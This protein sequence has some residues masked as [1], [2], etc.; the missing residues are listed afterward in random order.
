MQNQYVGD[1]GDFGKYGM[2]RALFPEAK[3]GVV[4]Y[5]VPNETHNNDGKH[6]VYLDKADYR[7][8]DAV[9]AGKLKI[10]IRDGCRSV[11][12]IEQ[13]G[14][15]NSHTVFY[16][17]QLTYDGITA[18]GKSDREKRLQN[19]QEWLNAAFEA[20]RNCEV[21]FLDPDNGLQI[22]SCAK[23][24]QVKSGM[25][26]FWDKS[27]GAIKFILGLCLL[28]FVYSSTAAFLNEFQTAD[29]IWRKYFQYKAL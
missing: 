3:L 6:V 24:N 10:L 26:K 17:R 12:K 14:L 22:P 20:T 11:E 15:F 19:R 25:A 13:L 21:I 5:L 9:L 23:I 8:C 18:N 16:N 1:I 2:L 28:V 4:W 7:K 27:F 29:A